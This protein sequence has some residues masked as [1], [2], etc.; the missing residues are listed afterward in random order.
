[1]TQFGK[2][3]AVL[4]TLL[5]VAF[6]GFA[7]AARVGGPNWEGQA[8]ALENYYVEKTSSNTGVTYTVKNRVTQEVVKKDSKVLP[9]VVFA[10]Y[11]DEGK[12]LRDKIENLA[13][14]LPRLE[15]GLK[16]VKAL[17]DV[18]LKA[19]DQRRNEL[20]KS[21]V[22]VVKQIQDL[23]VEGGK[24]AQEALTSWSEGELRREDVARLRN[25]LEEL[26]VDHFQTQ[27]QK[28][29]LLDELSRLRG[30]LARL[31]RRHQQLQSAAPYEEKT[32]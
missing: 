18:D 27:E 11:D 5:S 8:E 31:Q 14:E 4:T 20:E 32:Q 6:L 22:E 19:M 25:H 23:S 13:P 30:V 16:E 12:K 7:F 17:Q 15:K 1:M 10:A 3:L 24:V 29:R 26:E 21:F 9:E 28:K 2:I